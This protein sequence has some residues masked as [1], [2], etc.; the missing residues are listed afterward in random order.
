MTSVNT[1]LKIDDDY[2]NSQA[3]QIAEWACDLQEGIDGYIG[4][5]NHILE[6]AIMEGETAEALAS[7]AGYVENLK[8]IVNEMGEEAKGM[9]LA[10]LS[11]IDEADSYLY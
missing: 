1:E 2:V 8:D 4:I 11:E 5:L 6:D 3:E 7:F 10:F 9:C